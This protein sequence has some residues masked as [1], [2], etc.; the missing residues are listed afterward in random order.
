[1]HVGS[2]HR[3][4]PGADD[5][6]L[7]GRNF[8][9]PTDSRCS[10]EQQTSLRSNRGSLPTAVCS[11]TAVLRGVR[12]LYLIPPYLKYILRATMFPTKIVKLTE[13]VKLILVKLSEVRL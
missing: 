1:M 11:R 13:G 5:A 8:S 9:I 7:G 2:P 12:E 6:P 3:F 10:T 4:L